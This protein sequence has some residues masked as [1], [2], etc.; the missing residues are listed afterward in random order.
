MNRGERRGATR[1]G[2][3]RRGDAARYAARHGPKPGVAMPLDRAP[4]SRLIGAERQITMPCSTT[5]ATRSVSSFPFPLGNAP[6]ARHQHAAGPMVAIHR[7]RAFSSSI[8]AAAK[9]TRLT[10]QLRIQPCDTGGRSSWTASRSDTVFIL[11]SP[12]FAD[13][14]GPS[15]AG[16]S[17]LSVRY[18]VEKPYAMDG[19]GWPAKQVA[20]GAVREEHLV[21]GAMPITLPPDFLPLVTIVAL[22]GAQFD[23]IWTRDVA[24]PRPAGPP[25]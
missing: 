1:T 12:G 22:E 21:Q 15:A 14:K 6:R 5:A 24:L 7:F 11:L 10:D 19:D 16:R 18:Y 25:R 2:A 17:S 3:S 4:S 8:D 13:A 20:A 9:S 23:H